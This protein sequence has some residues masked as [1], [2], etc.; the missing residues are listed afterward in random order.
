[1]NVS[2]LIV[3]SLSRLGVARVYGLIGVSILDLLDAF[4]ESSIRYISTRHEQVAVSMA[5]AEGRLSHK[6]GVAVV[7]AGPGMLNSVISIAGAYKD[8]S[9]LLVIGGGVRRR[10]KGLDSWLEVDQASILRPVTKFY[11]RIEK[12]S[13][14]SKVIAEAYSASISPP[15]GPAFVEVPEDIWE[16]EA[17]EEIAEVKPEPPPLPDEEKVSK[18]VKM[19]EESYRP[20]ILAGGGVNNAEASQYLIS[21]AKANS[22]PVAI[23]GNGRGSFPE[24]EELFVGRAGFG[25]GSIV[26]D[27]ALEEADL[28]IAVGAGISDVTTYGYLVTPKGKKVAVDLDKLAERKPIN[29]SLH[30]YCDATSFLSILLNSDIRR[31]DRREWLEAIA[32][33]KEEWNQM[34]EVS[35]AKSERG[36]VNPSKFFKRMNSALDED[37]IITAG[38]G[39]HIVYTYDYLKLRRPGSFLAATNLG[40]MGFAF[41]AALGAKVS[42]PENYVIAVLGDGEFLMTLQDLETAYREKIGVKI[43]VVNDNT[44]RVLYL[45]QKLQKMG[46][47]IGTSHSNPDIMK[48]GEAFGIDALSIDS[49]EQIDEGIEFVMKDKQSPSILELKINPDDVP[50]LNLEPSSRF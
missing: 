36:Y 39:V 7:H 26:A 27:Y 33:K 5:D 23:T 28:V 20:L 38:Q 22:I 6:P 15:Y 2:K 31:T 49:D 45:R 21:V 12:P 18:L 29:L 3:S 25:G 37:V 17:G 14:T 47:L 11:A 35:A 32:R 42:R 8:S 30:L 10:M 48:L 41:P 16:A 34:L 1:M 46:R 24:D 43:I 4:R 40:A 13:E 44:Y 19:L 9:P 50:P